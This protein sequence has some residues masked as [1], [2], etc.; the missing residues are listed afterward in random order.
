MGA[1]LLVGTLV[2][3]NIWVKISLVYFSLLAISEFL[4][5]RAVAS[6]Y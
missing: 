1:L 3:F 2:P 5:S 4:L 6:G